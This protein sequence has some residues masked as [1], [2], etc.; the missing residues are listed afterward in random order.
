MSWCLGQ[1]LQPEAHPAVSSQDKGWEAHSLLLGLFSLPDALPLTQTRM[2][3]ATP[4]SLSSWLH[5]LTLALSLC[6]HLGPFHPRPSLHH[7][8]YR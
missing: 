6:G 3:R 4:P 2:Q 5:I 8:H 1:L 7:L